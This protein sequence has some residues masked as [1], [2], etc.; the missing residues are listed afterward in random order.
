MAAQVLEL[1]NVQAVNKVQFVV[2][3]FV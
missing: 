3:M 1:Q 2:F